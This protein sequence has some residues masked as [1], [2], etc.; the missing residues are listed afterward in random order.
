MHFCA[1]HS[2]IHILDHD[3]ELQISTKLHINCQTK[4]ASLLSLCLGLFHY[5]IFIKNTTINFFSL[6]ILISKYSEL[7]SVGVAVPSV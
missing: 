2:G 7:D 4:S 5:F 6:I 3:K 1:K